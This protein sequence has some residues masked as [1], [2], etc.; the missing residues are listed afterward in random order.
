MV[1]H[2]V[3][4][5]PLVG[6]GGSGP[7]RALAHGRQQHRGRTGVRARRALVCHAIRNLSRPL[8]NT[9]EADGSGSLLDT[10][11]VVWAKELGDSRLHDFKAV[12]FIIAGGGNGNFKTGR[13][14]KFN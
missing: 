8:E 10:S 5:N 1:A 11:T 3:A 2:G 6:P 9:Q 14:L 7:P 13:Y 12:P 4:R